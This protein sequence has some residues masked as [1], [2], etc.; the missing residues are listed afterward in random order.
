[1][2]SKF[3]KVKNQESI[4]KKITLLFFLMIFML[5]SAFAITEKI[6]W[7]LEEG[8]GSIVFDSSGNDIN[9]F[10]TNAVWSSSFSQFGSYSIDM[11]GNDDYITS[12]SSFILPVNFT[13]SFW[14]RKDVDTGLDYYFM[15]NSIDEDLGF[16]VDSNTNDIYLEYFN[17]TGNLTT[18]VL[19]NFDVPNDVWVNYVI[20]YSKDL[21][22][23]DYYRDNTQILNKTALPGG[24]LA[25]TTLKSLRLGADNNIEN[26]L[27]GWFDS[28][29]GFDGILNASQIT[30]VFSNEPV[31]PGVTIPGSEPP[32]QNETTPLTGSAQFNIINSSTPIEG[33]NLTNQI[34]LYANLNVQASC[35]IYIDNSLYSSVD[36][37]IAY[38]ELATLSLGEHTYFLYCDFV[39]GGILY[40]DFTQPITFN[41]IEGS[42]STINFVFSSSEFAVNS[43]SLYVVT[44][45]LDSGIVIPSVTKP[46]NRLANPGDAYFEQ[47]NNG[48]ASFTLPPGNHEFCMING[49]AQYN[50][51]DGFSDVWQLN[52]VQK[53][54]KLGDYDIPSNVTTTFFVGLETSDLYELTNPKW[55]G[56]SW[57]QIIGGLILLIIG[58]ICI[59]IGVEM[60]EP[61]AIVIG[62]LISAI[63]LGFQVG[64]LVLGVLT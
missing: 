4:M 54:L 3:I 51:A 28:F 29:R 1:M 49:I 55:W 16:I 18:F 39:D 13:L 64:T 9:G 21:N 24:Y 37:I 52:Q 14:V 12:L 38:N 48:Q 15:F 40:Y 22:E 8:S 26:E 36:N 47:L 56:T 10:L 25:T 34:N 6:N 35:D 41:V 7:Q 5:S 11:D 59:A 23:L 2:N 60:K 27:N 43:Q 62:A 17:S 50:T 31:I 33:T 30:E 19:E 46:Y 32:V 45:C 58:I 20:A 57:T 44:P 61:R 63:A 53:Q 42:P